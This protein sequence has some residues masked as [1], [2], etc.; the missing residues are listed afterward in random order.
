MTLNV[1]GPMFVSNATVSNQVSAVVGYSSARSGLSG[2][3]IGP[4]SNVS[5]PLKNNGL[6]VAS[7][8][9][10]SLTPICYTCTYMVNSSVAPILLSQ[11]SNISLA[12]F[13]TVT[14]TTTNLVISNALASSV[15]FRYNVTFYP[16]G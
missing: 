14:M 1:L 7:I 9:D 3:T 4:L 8:Y 2:V 6:V 13:Y 12:G 16:I 10:S 15:V 11:A 5:I